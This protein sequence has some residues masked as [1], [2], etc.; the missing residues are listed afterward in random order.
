MVWSDDGRVEC[1]HCHRVY[2]GLVWRKA[3]FR[4]TGVVWC[5]RINQVNRVFCSFCLLTQDRV[6]DSLARSWHRSISIFFFPSSPVFPPLQDVGYG[7]QTTCPFPE[8]S[9]DLLTVQAECNRMLQGVAPPLH[10]W[11]Q[12]G[13]PGAAAAAHPHVGGPAVAAAPHEGGDGGAEA[14]DDGEHGVAAAAEHGDDAGVAAGS[15]VHAASAS[16]SSGAAPAA[17]V[18]NEGS[19]DRILEVLNELVHR[20]RALELAVASLRP[21]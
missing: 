12:L 4:G 17:S 13:Q 15:T 18:E 11:Q 10:P 3:E 14:A 5:N 2:R 19:L 20:V 8:W 1:D 9:T 16:S 21:S 7:V 6:C